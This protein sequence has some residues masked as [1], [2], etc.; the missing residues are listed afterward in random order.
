MGTFGV[1]NP[2]KWIWSLFLSCRWQWELV[3]HW[4]CWHWGWWKHRTSLISHVEFIIILF[5]FSRAFHW[6]LAY[7]I[8]QMKNQQ[9]NLS[10]MGTLWPHFFLMAISPW[11][12]IHKMKKIVFTLFL[13]DPEGENTLCP[14]TLKLHSKAPHY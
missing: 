7:K 1:N 12:N 11:K 14:P 9:E 13:S 2:M 10:L 3:W 6:I 8:L 4:H 5:N